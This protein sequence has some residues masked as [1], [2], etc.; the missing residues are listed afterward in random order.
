MQGVELQLEWSI[1]RQNLLLGA[2]KTTKVNN[3][4][5]FTDDPGG[6]HRNPSNGCEINK[7][8]QDFT[9]IGINDDKSEII[10][11]EMV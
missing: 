3:G 4:V 8:S 6:S 5:I 11:P 9:Q 10:K 1:S 2:R 7:H